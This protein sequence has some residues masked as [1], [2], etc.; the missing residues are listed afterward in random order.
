MAGQESAVRD[1]GEC[2]HNWTQSALTLEVRKT[3]KVPWAS[4]KKSPE[5]YVDGVRSID[6][7][8]RHLKSG[9]IIRSLSLSPP[10]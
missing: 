5:N 7:G 4:R 8:R 2:R 9:L 1:R 6:E 3:D 10:R